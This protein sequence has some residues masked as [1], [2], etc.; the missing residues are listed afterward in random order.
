MKRKMMVL[1]TKKKKN[2]KFDLMP[3]N[4]VV[5]WHSVRELLTRSPEKNLN[6]NSKLKLSY[7]FWSAIVL[8]ILMMDSLVYNRTTSEC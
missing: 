8:M 3:R 7:E 6:D 5:L 2:S 4:F 1:N